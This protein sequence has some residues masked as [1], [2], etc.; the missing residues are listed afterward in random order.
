ML[1]ALRFLPVC[2]ALLA[3]LGAAAQASVAQG[4][5]RLPPGARV[6]LM[7]LDIELYEVSGGG[8]VEP[9]ADWTLAASELVRKALMGDML[10]V[11]VH[12]LPGEPDDSIAR[13]ALL[14]RAVSSAVVVHHYGSLKLPTKN[15]ALDWSLGA[16]EGALLGARSG[17][18]YALFVWMR[19]SYASAARKATM[20]VAALFGLPVGGGGQ[21]AYTSLVDLRTGR[22]VWF[23]KVSRLSGDLRE[24]DSARETLDALFAGFPR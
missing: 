15:G 13:V 3:P 8:A 1:R 16:E 21:T 24:D 5:L 20:V 2:A 4:F 12:E 7:P 11:M 19:D 10:G 18:D 9:R 17:A 23:N 22:L 14:H 6:V